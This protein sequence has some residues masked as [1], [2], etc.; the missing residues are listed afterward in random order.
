MGQIESQVRT[1]YS[2]KQCGELFQKAVR[3]AQGVGSQVG[4]LAAKL[5]GNDNSG[6][7]TP[8]DESPFSELNDDPPTFVVGAFIPK[9]QGGALGNGTHVH[10]YVWDRGSH[11]DVEFYSP[12]GFGGGMHAS[13][14]VK[15]CI[16]TFG[17]ATQASPAQQVSA[18][19][20]SAPSPSAIPAP[21]P[22]PAGWHGDPYRAHELRYWDGSRWT[23]H[24]SNGG[25]VS[26]DPR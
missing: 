23:E 15:S 1:T 13:K 21:P 9:L 25:V 8:R 12:H 10:M 20:P 2:V 4:R 14:L 6:F 5:M 17:A 7:Y 11:R 18:P 26:A 22:V 3:E 24:V 19:I 16:A